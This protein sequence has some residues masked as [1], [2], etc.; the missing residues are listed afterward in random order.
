MRFTTAIA[1]ALTAVAGIAF[2]SPASA[3][4]LD[5]VK[6]RG[7]LLCGVSGKVPGFSAPDAKGVWSGL[8]VDYCRA[9]AAAV[10]NDPEKV[11]FVP[12]TTTERFTAL[13]SGEIDVL[14]RNTTWTFSRDAN[15]GLDFVGIMFHDGQGFMV[16]KKLGVTSVKGLNGAS[17]CIQNGTTTEQVVSDYFA[18]NGMKYEPVAFESADEA[19]KI[20][21]SGRCDVYTT[22]ASGLAARR[23]TLSNPKDHV[24]LPEIISKE[25]LGPAVRQGDQQWSHITRWVLFAMINAEELGVTSKN[26]DQMKASKN[27]DIRRLIGEDD[28]VYSD[29]FGLTK[30]WAFRAIKL[31]GNYGEVFDRNVGPAT[32][33]GLERGPN[34]LWIKGGLL[35]AP[36]LR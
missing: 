26:V 11:K 2:T 35:F 6:A 33:L 18:A 30:D 21:D 24:I 4:I 1:L 34:Q 16:N 12:V 8:D 22:D 15:I 19:A 9:V 36:P 23:T 7:Q 32:A 14:A 25:P 13:Q 28:S 5:T 17:I 10:F 29:K 31:V 3:G 27:P 20:Y